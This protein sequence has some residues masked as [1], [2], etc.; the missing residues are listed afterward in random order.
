M[1]LS[2]EK[3]QNTIIICLVTLIVF[4]GAF[5]VSALSD[6]DNSYAFNENKGNT[7]TEKEVYDEADMKAHTDIKINEYL[8][9]KKEDKLNI[10]YVARPTCGYCEIQDPIL[11]HVAFLHD[12]KVNYLNTDN[13]SNKDNSKFMQSDKKFE[14]GYGTPMILIT[15]NDKIIDSTPGL[16]EKD[17]LIKF[18]KDNGIIVEK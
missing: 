4:G 9:L 6:K 3:I 14:N 15:K 13:F 7:N 8:N 1:K 10:I 16:T 5:F 11:R 18:F 2:T 17:P 12:L